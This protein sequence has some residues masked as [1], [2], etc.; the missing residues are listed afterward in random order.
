MFWHKKNIDTT[1]DSSEA[2]VEIS[3]PH[4]QFMP[5][6]NDETKTK[7]INSI[8]KSLKSGDN[9]KQTVEK[10]SPLVPDGYD[11]EEIVRTESVF[12]SAKK[13]YNFAILSNAVATEWQHIPNRK[14]N[15]KTKQ[16]EIHT[17]ECTENEKSGGRYIGH[18][19][20][21]GQLIPPAHVGCRC[22]IRVMYK[23]DDG[24]KNIQNS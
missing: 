14:Y 10:V 15:R 7:I 22:G 11:V 20:P 1:S 21:S 18:K 2:I 19:Y 3:D 4:S 16:Y 5:S 23:N 13:I 24:L 17:D 9:V 12:I 6:F 8:S